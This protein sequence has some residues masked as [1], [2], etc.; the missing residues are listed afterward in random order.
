MTL[1][2]LGPLIALQDKVTM[3]PTCG[4]NADT[5][6]W[7][8]DVNTPNTKMLL[9]NTYIGRYHTCD[10]MYNDH[11]LPRCFELWSGGT[12]NQYH[13]G[14]IVV[15]TSDCIGSY[16]KAVLCQYAGKYTNARLLIPTAQILSF[17]FWSKLHFKWSVYD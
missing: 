1:Q 16:S 15:G 5:T 9:S 14:G 8:D 17:S 3:L 7:Y 2:N 6:Y 10:D 11:V 4:L 13:P 12:V